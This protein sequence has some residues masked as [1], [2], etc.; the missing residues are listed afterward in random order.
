M[1]TRNF[2]TEIAGMEYFAKQKGAVKGKIYPDI[3]GEV[4]I[5][6][7]LCPCPSCS[8]VFQQFSQMFPNLK[9]TIVTTN[10]LHY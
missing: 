3:T 2:D 5:T 4:K 1:K 6:S 8:A 9:I 10:K 7:D